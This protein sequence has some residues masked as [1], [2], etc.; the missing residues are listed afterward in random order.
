MRWL[1]A[2]RYAPTIPDGPLVLVADALRLSF[3]RQEYT[4]YDMAIKPASRNLAYFMEPVLL[5]GRESAH[6]W[7]HAINT[8]APQL[9]QR[10]VGLVADGFTGA[11]TICGEQGW[12]QQRCHWH[13]LATFGG[14]LKPRRRSRKL[15]RRI[16][17]LAC[18]AAW[19]V[20]HTTDAE[21]LETALGV[22]ATLVPMVP[23]RA[24]RLPG[25]IRQFI[26]DSSLGRAYLTSPQ[27]GL[28]TTTAVLESLHGRIRSIIQR[29][30][31]PE[32]IQRRVSCLVRLAPTSRCNPG[33]HQQN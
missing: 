31:K 33:N 30:R 20:L 2:R 28:P 19:L 26:A 29:T 17:D 7:R 11:D 25:V 22:L 15:L 9:R 3:Q 8:I 13:M 12:I 21:R 10:I 5:T 6:G 27:L 23:H 14:S 32:A 1:A 24:Q 16:R 18:L 4:L